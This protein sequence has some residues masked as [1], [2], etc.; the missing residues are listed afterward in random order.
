MVPFTGMNKTGMGIGLEMEK[1]ITLLWI[2]IC[3]KCEMYN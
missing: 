2:N 1:S 3:D